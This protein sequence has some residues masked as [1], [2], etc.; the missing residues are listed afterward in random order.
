MMRGAEQLLPGDEEV[1]EISLYRKYNRCRD[2]PLQVGDLA[3]NPEL[4]GLEGEALQLHDLLQDE[5]RL[6][7]FASSYS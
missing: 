4:R 6:V 1:R 5:R 7:V 2:G 3:P